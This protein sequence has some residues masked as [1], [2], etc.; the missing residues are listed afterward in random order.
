MTTPKPER[1]ALSYLRLAGAVLA[2]TLAPAIASA[3][4]L[5][6]PSTLAYVGP[7]AGLGAIGALLAV[8]AAVVVGLAGLVLYPMRLL[9]NWLRGKSEPDAAVAEKTPQGST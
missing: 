7:G 4:P 3:A 1:S 6:L 2:V 5:G 9:S 8:L